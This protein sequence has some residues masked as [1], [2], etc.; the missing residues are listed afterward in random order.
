MSAPRAREWLDSTT[1]RV[2][3]FRG[4]V[5]GCVCFRGLRHAAERLRDLLARQALLLQERALRGLGGGGYLRLGRAGRGTGT[6]RAVRRRSRS[7]GT[8][9][10]TASGRTRRCGVAIARLA[11]T[12]AGVTSAPAGAAGTQRRSGPCRRAWSWERR[13]PPRSGR[14]RRRSWRAMQCPSSDL[15][16]PASNHR[17]RHRTG[18]CN[19]HPRARLTRRTSLIPGNLEPILLG[20]IFVRR[21]IPRTRTAPRAPRASLSTMHASPATPAASL[22][23]ARAP[24]AFRA[25]TSPAAAL[26]PSWT[27]SSARESE[28]ASPRAPRVPPRASPRA[29]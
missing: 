14:P 12:G 20:S 28:P 11:A 2:C 23:R 24:R 25:P 26:R 15:G 13:A 21:R 5:G 7:S 22:T 3:R 27:A 8:T 19:S 10:W 4:G 16:A 1:P 9:A 17:A 29:V 18:N 6:V